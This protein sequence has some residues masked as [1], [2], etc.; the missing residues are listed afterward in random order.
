MRE[1]FRLLFWTNRYRKVQVLETEKWADLDYERQIA[2]PWERDKQ[3]S[4]VLKE[5]RGQ[6]GEPVEL[7][8]VSRREISIPR[9][10]KHIIRID[11]F[12]TVE[13]MVWR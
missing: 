6:W 4:E 7:A 1:K 2:D 10:K 9:V 11:I 3:S 5:E 12:K 8:F 13:L